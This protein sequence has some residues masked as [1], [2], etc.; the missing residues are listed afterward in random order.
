MCLRE[1]REVCPSQFKHPIAF[2]NSAASPRDNAL[3][4]EQNRWRATVAAEVPASRMDQGMRVETRLQ[5]GLQ[6]GFVAQW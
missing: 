3:H 5:Q 1:G 6:F 4:K 2:R